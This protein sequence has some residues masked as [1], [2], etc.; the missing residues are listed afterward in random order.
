M[1]D[2]SL[3]G[4]VPSSIN[5][6]EGSLDKR[7]RDVVQWRGLGEIPVYRL[8][9]VEVGER[10][11][12]EPIFH[13]PWRLRTFPVK[14]ATVL[15]VSPVGSGI[16]VAIDG[17]GNRGDE[18]KTTRW[19]CSTRVLKLSD[20][21]PEF[22][23]IARYGQ[24]EAEMATDNAVK[25]L[26]KRYSFQQEK[27]VTALQAGNEED[28]EKAQKALEKIQHEATAKGVEL[29]A[30]VDTQPPAMPISPAASKVSLKQANEQRK[31][32]LAKHKEAQAVEKAARPSTPR[33]PKGEKKLRPCLEGCGQMVPG[34]FAMGHDAKLKSL[35]IRI[36]R[37]ENDPTDLPDVVKELVKFKTAEKVVERDAQGKVKSETQ[38]YICVQAPVRIPGRDSESFMVTQRSD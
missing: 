37:G 1:D 14:L 2:T 17:D 24:S 9:E 13:H 3:I 10:V 21:P 32:A 7:S 19:A 20:V 8:D 12:D 26:Q 22:Q 33:A 29:G 18:P 6:T 5:E 11:M 38:T 28:I 27:L 31:A 16:E 25:A 15:Y 34:N 36:E 30:V 35:I 23:F 4:S